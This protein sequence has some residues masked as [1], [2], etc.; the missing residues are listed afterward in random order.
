LRRSPSDF[1][2]Q[3]G[4]YRL[5]REFSAFRV[6]LTGGTAKISETLKKLGFRVEI[7]KK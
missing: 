4:D 1:E 6:E 7:V 3:R 2:K 5:R